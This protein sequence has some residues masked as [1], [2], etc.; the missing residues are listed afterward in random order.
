MVPVYRKDLAVTY[1]HSGHLGDLIYALYAIKANGGGNLIIGQEQKDTAPCAEPICHSQFKMLLWLLKSQPYIEDAWYSATHPGDSAHDLNTFRNHW[2]NPSTR[3]EHNLDTLCKAHF[4]ELGVLEK[5]NA[6]YSWIECPCPISTDRIV[7]HRSAR[8]NS[9][10]FGEQSFPWGAL[11]N[12]HSDNML[13]VGLESE[14]IKFQSDFEHRVS[15]WQVKDFFE[16]ARLIAGAR[17]CIFNQSF[18]LSLALGLGKRVACEA[19]PASPD[20]RFMR[21]TYTDQLLTPNYA[22]LTDGLW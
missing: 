3:S 17:S 10:G 1:Y 19:W 9:P 11:V 21:P 16:L 18:P 4:H 8:Y 22:T 12:R 2:V 13:F 20:C 6:E 5:F 15:F 14:W 7:V